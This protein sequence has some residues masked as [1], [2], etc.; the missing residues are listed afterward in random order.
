[1]GKWVLMGVTHHSVKVGWGFGSLHIHRP[2]YKYDYS[3]RP[4]WVDLGILN[5]FPKTCDVVFMLWKQQVSETDREI[6]DTG[7]FIFFSS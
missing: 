2:R 3:C 6:G 5:S 1:M 4:R 7:L